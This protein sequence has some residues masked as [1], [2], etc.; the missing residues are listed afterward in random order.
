MR[1]TPFRF[2]KCHALDRRADEVYHSS[3]TYPLF[4]CCL[5]IPYD[6]YLRALQLYGNEAAFHLNPI[7]R[8][9]FLRW[10]RTRGSCIQAYRSQARRQGYNPESGKTAPWHGI[11]FPED[12]GSSTIVLLTDGNQDL[13][14]IVGDPRPIPD[15]LLQVL[16][17]GTPRTVSTRLTHQPNNLTK[18]VTLQGMSGSRTPVSND[19]GSTCVGGMEMAVVVTEL[20]EQVTEGDID[21]YWKDTIKETL[22]YIGGSENMAAFLNVIYQRFPRERD[23]SAT[24]T[25]GRRL[26]VPE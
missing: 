4:F 17:L 6:G 9:N 23:D 5:S 14:N 22:G 18:P 3:F 16:D 21:D 24:P 8:Q 10:S 19:F 1:Q 13:A 12:P 20:L 11:Y 7:Q 25:I 26:R 15:Q 2:E